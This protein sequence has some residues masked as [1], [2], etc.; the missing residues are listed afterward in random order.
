MRLQT[1]I[2]EFLGNELKLDPQNISPD[3]A[4]ADLGLNQTQISDIL[5]RLQDALGITLPE[6]KDTSIASVGDLLSL[7]EEDQPEL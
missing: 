2:L 1:A 5:N 4:F 7:V 3:T 6:D